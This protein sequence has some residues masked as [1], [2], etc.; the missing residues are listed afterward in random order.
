MA[1]ML[2]FP[3]G[4]V[5]VDLYDEG[6]PARICESFTR[7]CAR[8]YYHGCL[9]YQVQ[10]GCL[11]QMGDPTGTGKGGCC[12]QHNEDAAFPRF[13][14]HAPSD[15]RQK[16][17]RAGLVSVVSMG[18]QG[19]DHLYGSQFFF[20]LRDEDLDHLDAGGHMVIGEVA[21]GLDVL[22]KIGALYLDGNGRPWED[23]RIQH[24]HVLENPFAE[25]ECPPSPERRPETPAVGERVTARVAYGQAKD[26]NDGLTAA[27]R[28]SQEADKKARSQAEVLEMIGDLPHADV[29]VPKNELFIAKLN[30]AT[31]DADLEL[32]FSRFG[33]IESCD[34]VRDWKTGDSLNFAFIAFEEEKSCVEAYKKMNNV[35]IDDSRIRV[36]FSQ[37][38]AKIWSR[39]TMQ[40]KGSAAAKL[41]E[42]HRKGGGAPLDAGHYGPGGPATTRRAYGGR[43]GEDVYAADHVRDYRGRLDDRDRRRGDRRDPGR[44]LGI[45]GL[46]DRRDRDRSRRDRSRERSRRDRDRERRKRSRSR[47]R[48]R[49]H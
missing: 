31:E 48:S 37:S 15:D 27:E 47:E 10:S 8:K 30:K 49:R 20:T 18:S 3:L 26:A 42:K 19:N 25:L 38:V 46:D 40:Y 5:V 12:S 33:R 32:I 35:L 21:E 2:Q 23:V 9:V 41:R 17:D 16:H 6:E 44:S 1:V 13:I 4:D 45:E 11:A 7:L 14:R 29:E 28:A 36:D 22:K 34:I 24:T 39:Y 43:S